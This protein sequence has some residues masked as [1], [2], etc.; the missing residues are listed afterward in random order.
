MA[1]IDLDLGLP[2]I[3]EPSMTAAPEGEIGGVVDFESALVSTAVNPD[4]A[5][6]QAETIVSPNFASAPEPDMLPEQDF[7]F[8]QLETQLNQ[9]PTYEEP[10]S[11]GDDFA[12]TQE[13][14][15]VNPQFGASDDLLPD[16]EISANEEVATKLDLAKAYE[17]MGDFEG[18]SE[19][20]QEVLKEGDAAQKERAQAI[21]A[22][23]NT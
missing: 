4:F 2:E 19:L 10:G 9:A 1:S 14:T 18:A 3:P 15:V 13:E 5:R 11:A 17:E 12:T 21:L 8:A 6:E 7:S 23:I 20:L 22:K 16:F